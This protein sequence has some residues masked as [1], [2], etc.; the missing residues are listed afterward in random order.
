M[1]DGSSVYVGLDVHKDSIA[2]A[3]LSGSGSVPEVW[4]I[5]HEPR[6]VR[7][8]ASRLRREAGGLRVS[9]CYEAGS[10]GYALQRQLREL[11]VDCAVVAPSLVPRKAGERVKTDRRDARKLC[12]YWR[13][14]ALTEVHPPTPEQEAVRDLLRCR[15]D[16]RGDLQRNR[17]RLSKLLLRRA[18]VYREGRQW[19]TR[20]RAW[21]RA[22]SWQ[23][24]ADQ[25]VFTEY[26]LCIELLE[27][28]LRTL[29]QRLVEVATR[30]PYLEPVGWLRCFRGIDTVTAMTL[31]AEVHGFERFTSARCFMA[32]LGLVPGESSSGAAQRRTGITKT[33][34]SHVRRLLVEAAWHYR[35]RPS[36]GAELRRRRQDQPA[37]VIA[38]ADRAQRRLYQRYHRLVA[39]TKPAPKVVTALARELAGFVW[40]AVVHTPRAAN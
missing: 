18:L 9:C 25:A 20:H 15:D 17:H 23:H 14:G 19:T 32:Y 31:I 38:L 8:L 21:L 28:R 26:L 27:E 10:C 33:G 13:S 2:V 37:S 35:H 36:V 1:D 40:A 22:L 34:N 12:V 7:R 3:R 39:L 4:E 29:D 30:Q 11:G 16:L 24:S 5:P 6:A